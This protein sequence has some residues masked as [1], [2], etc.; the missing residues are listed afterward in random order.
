MADL[1]KLSDSDLNALAAGNLRDVSDEGLSHLSE[2]ARQDYSP[3][4]PARVTKKDTVAAGLEGIKA[5]ITGPVIGIAQRLGLED[6]QGAADI[7]R[8]DM[9][10]INAKGG[11]AGQVIG[12]LIAAAP[13]AMIPGA[14]TVAGGA[15]TGGVMGAT[16]PTQRGE[17]AVLNAGVGTIAGG[18]IPAAINVTKG[19]RA[20]VVDPFTEAGRNRMAGAVLK[21]MAGDD[22]AGV[23][24]RLATATG[25][26]P[27]FTP[28]VAQAARN[29]GI[30]AFERTM[31]GV[32]P[33]AFNELDRS[34]RGALV[35]ALRSV[36][37]TPEEKAAADTLRNEAAQSLYGKA[38]QS[39]AMRRDLAKIQ[40]DS[41]SM[42]MGGGIHQAADSV[43]SQLAD[44]L[45]TP[46]LRDLATRP[47]FAQAVQEAKTLAANKGARL[48][49]PL[50]SLEGLHYTKLALDDMAN[51]GAASALGRNANAARSDIAST[52]SDEMSNISPLYGNARKTF[53]EMSKPINQMEIG[54]SLYNRFV[55][56]LA[57]QGNLPFRTNAQSYAAALRNGDEIAKSATGFKGATLEGIM[58]PE[59]MKLLRGV[60][61]D[62]EAKAAAEGGGRGVG[63]DT[64]QKIAMSNIAAEAGIPNWLSSIARVPG[65]WMKRA[66][67]VLYGNADEQ[68]RNNLAHLLT[69]PSEAAKA[70]ESAGLTPSKLA[71]VLKKASQA[72]A[73]SAPASINALTA[74]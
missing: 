24:N 31:R 58:T 44:D 34:Q 50:Q 51:P 69:N 14:N 10:D 16:Q 13:F 41:K 52:L 49:D 47:M 66:G 73:L 60:A 57:D 26:T 65:G 67:D 17:S 6:S 12:G 62:A 71:E 22:A 19:A 56:A 74:Q 4:R 35:D 48:S 45:A 63:S 25:E 28:S 38:F 39:D 32:N 55:P 5:A 33:Q 7:W 46:G 72:A 9:A 70:M 23:A 18:A 30:S 15:L 40:L 1:T 2:P 29:D 54:Q 36:A 43:S 21:R 64:V 68:V 42:V 8:G 11:G 59:Q 27:G 53:T 61:K 37:K 20:M 3:N